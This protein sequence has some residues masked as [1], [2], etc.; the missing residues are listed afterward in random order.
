MAS[1]FSE[2]CGSLLTLNVSI[3]CG[4]QAVGVPDSPHTLASLIPVAAAMV[5]VLQWVAL[6][7]FSCVVLSI[8]F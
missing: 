4:L 6:D 5:L 8:T 3:N 7:G 1:S 2:N